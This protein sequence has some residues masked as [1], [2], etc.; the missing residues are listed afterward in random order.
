MKWLTVRAS[1]VNQILCAGGLV[2]LQHMDRPCVPLSQTTGLD[3]G[4]RIAE[5]F[6]VMARLD[7]KVTLLPIQAWSSCPISFL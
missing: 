5:E 2:S 1:S 4:T 6:G 3:T 7:Q